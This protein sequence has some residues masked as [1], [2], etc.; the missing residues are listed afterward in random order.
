MGTE[1]NI[2]TERVALNIAN[3]SISVSGLLLKLNRL[4]YVKDYHY[5]IHVDS[6]PKLSFVQKTRSRGTT[7]GQGDGHGAV[8]V[9]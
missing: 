5:K 7:G 2:T 6:T 9:Q 4:E 1:G 3:N 8:Y